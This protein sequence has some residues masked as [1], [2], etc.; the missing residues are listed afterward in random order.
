MTQPRALAIRRAQRG[1]VTADMH[2][3]WARRR[4]HGSGLLDQRR[5]NQFCRDGAVGGDPGCQLRPGFCDLSLWPQPG[6]AFEV[7]AIAAQPLVTPC[8]WRPAA[9]T[10]RPSHTRD[11]RRADQKP[12]PSAPVGRL[13]AG[14]LEVPRR[15]NRKRTYP[16]RFPPSIC[17]SCWKLACHFGHQTH[18]WNPK[19]APFIFGARNNIHIIDLAQTMPLLHQALVKVSDVVAERRPRAVRR[20]QAPGLRGDRRSRQALAPST[21]STIAGSAA[22]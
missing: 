12:R 18:R 21:S 3:A 22:R 20:H 19:M 7:L 11:L 15:I 6:R 4:I 1:E 8:K 2:V 13:Q 9:I 16:W 14:L 17:V 5:P 10:H